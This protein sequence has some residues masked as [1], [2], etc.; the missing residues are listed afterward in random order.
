MPRGG[1]VSG[2][3]QNGRAE[4]VIGAIGNIASNTGTLE[5][6]RNNGPAYERRPA[7]SQCGEACA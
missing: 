4:Q 2:S 1:R 3:F 7:A 6:G 5:Y